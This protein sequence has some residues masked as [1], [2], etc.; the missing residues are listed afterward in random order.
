MIDLYQNHPPDNLL[1]ETYKD[2]GE[3][4]RS[5]QDF[6][7]GIK[8]LEKALAIYELGDNQLHISQILN[9]IGNMYW[10]ASNLPQ[11]LKHYRA[12]LKLQ[13]TLSADTEVASSL[14]NIG[15]IFTM[16]GRYGRAIN[17]M[18]R[19][20]TLKKEIGNIVEIARSLNNLGYTHHLNGNQHKAVD[21]LKE[22]L[23]LNRRTGIRKEILHNLENLTAVMVTA[24]QLAESLGYLKEGLTLSDEL[25]DL[26]HTGAFNLS[27][28][29]VLRRLGRIKEAQRCVEDVNTVIEQV[30]DRVLPILQMTNKAQIAAAIGDSNSA[31]ELGREALSLSEELKTVP[32]QLNALLL[33]C[34][35]DCGKDYLTKAE[36]LIDQLGLTRER[37]LAR[38]NHLTA[39]LDNEDESAAITWGESILCLLD[40]LS[41]DIELARLWNLAA[42]V[43]IAQGDS[44]TAMK[45]LTKSL[46]ESRPSQLLFEQVDALTMIG[47]IESMNGEFESAFGRFK[48]ALSICKKLAGQLASDEEKVIY[49]SQRSIRFLTQEIKRLSQV[50][51]IKKGTSLN[52]SL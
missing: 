2:L 35:V 28:A 39:L 20:L 18:N 15:S 45:Y 47:Q 33:L 46:G 41:E 22:S 10:I 5:R 48:E 4:F 44:D 17:I 34:S 29:T 3:I 36:E 1:A 43:K 11:A 7:A 26:P 9:N 50:I 19:S 42:N 25:G 12:A 31:A 27:M 16:Q 6:D 38:F 52:S 13:R 51:G 40:G 24:G 23:E 8:A 14:S 30:D 37:T 49:L 21:C 32:E